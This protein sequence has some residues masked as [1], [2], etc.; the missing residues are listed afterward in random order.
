MFLKVALPLFEGPLD[1]LLHLIKQN[2]IDI[3]DI[4]IALITKQYLEYI[5]FM[6]ELD[7]EIA[8]EFLLM[9]ATLIYIKSKMLLPK[10][11]NEQEEEDPRQ[12][13]VEQLVEYEKFKNCTNYFKE[14]YQF[15]SNAF[16]RK[17]EDS[18][19]VLLSELNIFDLLTAL[20]KILERPEPKIYITQEV[21]KVEDKINYILDFLKLKKSAKFYELFGEYNRKNR[22]EIIVTFLALLELLRLK[23]VKAHQEQTFGEIYIKLEEENGYCN[24]VRYP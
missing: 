8:S 19:E 12:E 3:Y 15:W 24:S 20:K 1:L 14:R 13:L 6:K 9:A 21:V 17:V 4:P 18:E 2:K 10:Q 11:E 23:L 5:E 7:I 16:S 22:I